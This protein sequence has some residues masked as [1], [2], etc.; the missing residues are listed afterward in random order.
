VLSI[1]VLFG[2][3]LITFVMSHVIVP[4][5]VR[6]WVGLKTNQQIIAA[7]TARYHLNDP[8][9]LQYGYYFYDIVKGDWGIS[10]T[11]G[12]PVLAEIQTY[13]PATLE[14]V[15]AAAILSFLIGVPLGAIAAVRSNTKI[16]FS[17]STFYLIGVS[18]P[19]FVAALTFQLVFAY[20]IKLFPAT[21]ELS[22]SI[23]PPQLITG[24]MV[25]D[26]LLTGDWPAFWS[27]LNSLVLPTLAL[28]FLVF[29][30]FTR[31]ARSSMLDVLS[32]DYI[33]AAK[34]KGLNSYYVNI[35]HGLRTAL[36]PPVT[37]LA[38]VVGQLLGGVVV[39]EYVFGWPGI[40][41]YAVNAVET[42]NYPDVIGVTLLFAIG[43]V[44]SNLVADILYTVLDPRIRV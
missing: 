15:L 10:P 35:R 12:R 34:A 40:G 29:G 42:S 28:T 17:I 8:L 2:V 20:Y 11:T 24:M 4:N 26:S 36:I 22:A 33:R 27:S 25:L 43:V 37:L 30:L 18:S 21:G 41:S 38:V 13:F 3:T 5:P 32:K 16:D 6:A 9:W 1:P 7:Y 14:L 19:P 23:A 39:I 31:L 44:V